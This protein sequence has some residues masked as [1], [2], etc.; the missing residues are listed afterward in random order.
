MSLQLG[1][2]RR[3]L[4]QANLP[5]AD[6]TEAHLEHFFIHGSADAPEGVVGLELYPP[7]ALLR[8]LAVARAS[9]GKGIG[10]ALLSDA[11]HYARKHDVQEIYLLTATAERFFASR[12]YDRIERDDA[13][14]AIR[15]TQEYSTLCSATSVLMRKRL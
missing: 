2:V 4:G 6:L 3:L 10:S 8:S 11:E 1:T 13:P 12:G 7:A 5:L 9:R 15:A 14:P